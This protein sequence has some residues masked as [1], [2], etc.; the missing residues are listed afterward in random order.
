[1]AS[2]ESQA[3]LSCSPQA[4]AVMTSFLM[5]MD[6]ASRRGGGLVWRFGSSQVG[7]R[8]WGLLRVLTPGG[9]NASGGG[10]LG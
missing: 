7:P 6:H 3:P 9:N 4:I 5:M 8:F 1:M 2:L 10:V